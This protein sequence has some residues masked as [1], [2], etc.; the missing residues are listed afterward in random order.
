MA[1][2]ICPLCRLPLQCDAKTWHCEN[3]HSFDVAREGYVNLLPVQH[4]N[5]RDPGDDPKMV[6]ARRAFLQAGH[7]QP[8][9]DAVLQ[10][11]APLNEPSL[12]D[13]TNP[14]NVKG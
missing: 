13:R 7:Y 6:Q 4:K 1:H 2:I 12:L 14:A 3:R 9:R 5:S 11:L 10:L 8:L